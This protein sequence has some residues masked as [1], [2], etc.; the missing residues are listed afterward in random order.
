M[1]D[2]KKISD[3]KDPKEKIEAPENAAAEEAEDDEASEATAGMSKLAKKARKENR[4]QDRE[5]VKDTLSLDEQI[6]QSIQTGKMAETKKAKR[7]KYFRYGTWASI[8]LVGYLLYGWL[9]AP[10]VGG[11]DYGLCKVFLERYVAYPDYVRHI[12]VETFSS[13]ARIWYTQT[14]PYGQTRIEAI[15]CYYEQD[16]QR[17]VYLDKV[18]INRREIDPKLVEEFNAGIG[19]IFAY[20]PDLTYPSGFP[21]DIKS[22]RTGS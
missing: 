7:K 5:D 21:D 18:T 15:Q 3:E 17:G 13:S 10:F 22:L 4:K 8:T 19:A 14:D 6:E 9:F 16:N 11:M 1:A 2:D 20:P 12:S